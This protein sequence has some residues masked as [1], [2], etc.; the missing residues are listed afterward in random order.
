[1]Q[2]IYQ[3]QAV[4]LPA[5]T[6]EGI[7]FVSVWAV[8]AIYIEGG[9]FISNTGSGEIEEVPACAGSDAQRLIK[10]TLSEGEYSIEMQADGVVLE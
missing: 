2:L 1:M 7:R 9:F 10:I 6:P 8:P 4:D 5:S 3:G